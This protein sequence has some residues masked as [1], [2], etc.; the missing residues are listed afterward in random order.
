MVNYELDGKV[1]VVT[2]AGSGI[3]AE[4]ARVLSA[5]GARV[6]A[7]DINEAAASQV[8][9]GLASESQSVRVDTA[10]PDSVDAMVD[11]AVA[12]YGGL[13]IMVNNAGIG[14]ESATIADYSTESWRMVLSVNLDGVFYGTRAAV[15]AMR[16]NGGGSIINVASILGSVGFAMSSAYVAAKHGV[17]GL[18]KNVALEHSADGVR[19]NAI[20]PGFIKTP[21][22][23]DN[24]S[25]EAMDALVGQHP[26]G[27]LGR[28][29]EVAE[30][31][32]WLGSDASSFATG[33][34]YPV[35]GGYL[36]R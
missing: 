19:A 20:G 11:A 1:A 31:V 7:A 32:G 17:V 5:S 9:D 27:R 25:S 15:R 30:L 21:L 36:A 3:G 33:A 2:G 35:D 6:I 4:C 28:S 22:L 14:G 13:H 16:G 29:A 12:R 26:I 24:L 23:D 10:D 34:Y 18:T 8:S